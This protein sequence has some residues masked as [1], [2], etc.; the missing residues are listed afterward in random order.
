MR[1]AT[2]LTTVAV[3]LGLIA[4]AQAGES[5][6]QI[7]ANKLAANLIAANKLAANRL[8]ANKL[9]ANRLAANRLAANRIV[10]NRVVLNGISAAVPAGEGAVADIVGIEFPD[11]TSFTR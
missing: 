6:N 1:M 7:A 2:A 5:T 11:G 9:A 8:A 4:T 3:T 10:V